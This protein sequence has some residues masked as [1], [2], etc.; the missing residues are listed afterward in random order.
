MQNMFPLTQIQIRIPFPYC[1]HSTGICVQVQI[2]IRVR[3]LKYA[4]RQISNSNDILRMS[5][6]TDKNIASEC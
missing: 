2:R 1:L 4:I 6:Q 5:P 3:Q